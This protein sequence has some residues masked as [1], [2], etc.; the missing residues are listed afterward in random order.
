MG[1][2]KANPPSQQKPAAPHAKELLR[3]LQFTKSRTTKLVTS[4]SGLWLEDVTST[5]TKCRISPQA[6]QQG[7]SDGLYR[8]GKDAVLN[9]LAEAEAFRK[10]HSEAGASEAFA[11]QHQLLEQEVLRDDLGQSASVLRNRR[12]VPLA[13]LERMKA[14]NGAAYF[15]PSL[16]AA[17]E[18]LSRDFERAQL[19]PRV[20]SRWEPRLDS[21]K[22]AGRNHTADISDQAAS[23]RAKFNLA[24]SAIGPEL[25]GVVMDAICFEKGLEL[26][27]RER[28][29]PARS[30]K[31]MLRTGLEVLA[32][33]YQPK[34]RDHAPMRGWS[35]A[36]L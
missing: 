2:S 6:L 7:L 20:T 10:R 36:A 32:R 35:H 15:E 25:S 31:L 4:D 16:I 21:T 29:W 22:G 34:P 28:Q 1:R 18:K 3:L 13:G 24:V 8:I 17:A 9:E 12:S 33:H 14:S 30:A 11:R 19:G 23:A 5:S 26:I 27:E